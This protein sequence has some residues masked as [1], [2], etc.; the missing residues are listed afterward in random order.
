MKTD[1]RS[2]FWYVDLIKVTVLYRFV[3]LSIENAVVSVHVV[4]EKRIVTFP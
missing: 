1:D 4:K 2:D 3:S